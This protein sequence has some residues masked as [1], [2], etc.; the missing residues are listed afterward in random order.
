M[1]INRLFQFELPFIAFVVHQA[2]VAGVGE[3]DAAVRMNR[4]VVRRVERFSHELVGEH[5]PRTI[6]FVADHAA[7]SMLKADLS[8]LVVECVA[9]AV[10]G[11]LCGTR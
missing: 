5:F 6:V 2:A 3:P 8:A 10:A 9:V 7:I 11:G 1:P 4:T